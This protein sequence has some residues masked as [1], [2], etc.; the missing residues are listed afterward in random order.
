VALTTGIR[1][2]PYEIKS[3]LGEGGMVWCFVLTT[4]NFNVTLRSKLLPDH[5]AD[6][7]S[8]S[9]DSNAKPKVLA[10]LNHPNI[11]QI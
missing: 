11:A 3:P 6:D 1:I 10:S 9:Q 8:A 7:P 2:G 4:S 5:F